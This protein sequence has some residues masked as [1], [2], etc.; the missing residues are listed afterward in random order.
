LNFR[1]SKLVFVGKEDYFYLRLKVKVAA[2]GI[3]KNVLFT[4]FVPDKELQLYYHQCYC[5]NSA[6][7]YGRIWFAWFGSDA[8]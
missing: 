3:E 8:I 4:G 1:K 6:I 2:L 5:S 7:A